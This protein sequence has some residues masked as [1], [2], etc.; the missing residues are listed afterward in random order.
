M[1]KPQVNQ[2]AQKNP[3]IK[4]EKKEPKHLG[5]CSFTKATRE[6]MKMISSRSN[7][8][9]HIRFEEKKTGETYEINFEL[10]KIE[11]EIFTDEKGKTWKRIA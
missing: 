7:G 6:I 10:K 2:Q 5:S 1:S 3:E 9:D 4:I 11:A 8:I